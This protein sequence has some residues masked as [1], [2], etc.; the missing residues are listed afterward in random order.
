M[1]SVAR[2]IW[3]PVVEKVHERLALAVIGRERELVDDW[4]DVVCYC[5]LFDEFSLPLPRLLSRFKL[6]AGLP[7][8]PDVPVAALFSPEAWRF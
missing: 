2:E 5:A 3:S 4:K 1:L 7:P 6:V 8:P